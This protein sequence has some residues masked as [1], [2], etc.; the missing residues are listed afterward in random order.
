MFGRQI[1][2]SCSH[3]NTAIRKLSATTTRHDSIRN[4][5]KPLEMFPELSSAIELEA[6]G[7]FA[8]AFPLYV[9][10]H[11]VIASTM[12]PNTALAQE[13]VVKKAMLHM[14]EGKY[15]KAVQI[16]DLHCSKPDA[17]REYQIRFKQLIALCNLQQSKLSEAAAAAQE[18][19]DILETHMEDCGQEIGLAMFSPTYSVLGRHSKTQ[20]LFLIC[21]PTPPP[22]HTSP[23]QHICTAQITLYVHS[24]TI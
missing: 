19:V 3:A 11:E 13:L 1:Q 9:R 6:S 17:T 24:I 16:L 22:S 18:A 15:E 5:M 23:Y 7:S 2:F 12:G 10:M 21:T 14:Y 4:I 8:K 20:F